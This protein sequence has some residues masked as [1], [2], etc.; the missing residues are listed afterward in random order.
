ML[1]W[2][3]NMRK[4]ID[5]CLEK[6]NVLNEKVL[7]IRLGVLSF[8]LLLVYFIWTILF[9]SSMAHDLSVNQFYFNELNEKNEQLKMQY[10]VIQFQLNAFN[11]SE[12]ETNEDPKK[13]YFL[14]K[15]NQ[16]IFST[17]TTVDEISH[18][19]TSALNKGVELVS[20]DTFD[21]QPLINSKKASWIKHYRTIS[22]NGL[23]IK[24]KGNYLS[25]FHYLKTIEKSKL[26]FFWD[27]IDYEV[28]HYPLATVLIK[29]IFVTR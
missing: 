18:L 3:K 25:V 17:I 5:S 28:D 21:E 13:I 9:Q 24:L 4:K 27:E 26:H 15:K 19:F 2:K 23:L 14:D 10:E 1:S 16:V 29:V 20:L 11:L 6:L 12:N 7:P 8:C 22:K